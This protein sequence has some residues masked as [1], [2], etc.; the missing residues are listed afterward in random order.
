MYSVS[1]IRVHGDLRTIGSMHYTS[2][3]NDR[4]RQVATS[5][6][7]NQKIDTIAAQIIKDF[8]DT[9]PLFVAL[10]HG[11]APFAAKLMHAVVH[12]SPDYHP[13]MT[14]MIVST[15]GSEQTAGEP[16]IVTDLP[17]KM[18]VAGRD[19]VIIDDVLDKG[20]TADFVQQHL[21]IRGANAIKVAV[22]CDK[23]T[24]RERDV[25]AD[26]VGFTF[27]DNWLVGMGMDDAKSAHEA[28]RWLDEIWE[29]KQ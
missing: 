25:T 24:Q 6:Q 22:L 5:E 23:L 14:S 3:M 27:N 15:Y 8:P 10:L 17:P 16:H 19:V 20:I 13:D 12:A 11:A 18:T 9:N 1:R 29:V 2:A 28:Y 21:R 4:Y 26:Y 7:V